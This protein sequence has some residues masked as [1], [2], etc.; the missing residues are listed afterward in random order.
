MSDK[1]LAYGRRWFE[2]H[3]YEGEDSAD[4]DIWHH[5]HQPVKVLSKS[6]GVSCGSS[7]YCDMPRTYDVK[8][9]DGFE[10][11]VL[12]DELL[13]DPTEFDRPDYIPMSQNRHENVM[14]KL[15]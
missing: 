3:C 15:T 5:T 6:K 8:F 12:D 14:V 11:V 1:R 4:A 7:W 10:C 13:A 2:Y 9:A